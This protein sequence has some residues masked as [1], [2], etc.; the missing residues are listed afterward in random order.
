[1]GSSQPQPSFT[2]LNPHAQSVPHERDEDGVGGRKEE[3][4]HFFKYFNVIKLN[5]VGHLKILI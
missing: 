1:M 5:C 3:G 2:E 4:Y